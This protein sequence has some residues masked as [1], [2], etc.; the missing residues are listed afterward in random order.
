MFMPNKKC[1]A[2]LRWTKSL[3]VLD[4]HSANT[5]SLTL[6]SSFKAITP[7]RTIKSMAYYCISTKA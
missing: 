1:E 6:A 3:K 7:A 4:G 2:V 5:S